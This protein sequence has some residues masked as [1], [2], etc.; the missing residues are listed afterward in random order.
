MIEKWLAEVAERFATIRRDV[1]HV[2]SA[3]RGER[4]PLTVRRKFSDPGM[5]TTKGSASLKLV[6][7]DG[8]LTAA[9]SLTP[10]TVTVVDVIHETSQAVTLVVE[11]SSER[12]FSEAFAHF[13]PGQFVTVVTKID[14]VEY[15]RAYSICTTK[16]QFPRWAITTKRVRDGKVS[17]YLNEKIQ[18]GATL[19]VLGPSGNFVV[20]PSRAPS[21]SVR[22]LL[23]IAGG[24]GITPVFSMI[25]SLLGTDDSLRV[26][27]VYGNLNN[28]SIIF[29]DKLDTLAL[30]HPERLSLRHV[31]E[32]GAS[33]MDAPSTRTGR[34]D[35]STL[36]SLWNELALPSHT[37]CFLCG[38]EGMMEAAREM[39]LAAGVDRTA[40][41]EEK[42]SSPQKSSGEQA[43]QTE[44]QA[45]FMVRGKPR[46]VTI[47]PGKYLLESGIEAG[48][49]L[50]FSCT[51][52][53][54]GACKSKLSK[55]KVSMVEPNCLLPS[56]EA[57]GDIL[58]CVSTCL[59]DVTV[60]VAS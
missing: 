25:Q 52:G 16:E 45:T 3:L 51:M 10:R 7:S 49:D 1:A 5:P 15:R 24:S 11:E 6:S 56:E 35:R 59:S 29:R 4:A 20:G 31:L 50:P 30:N 47:K 18:V 38:P 17:N 39:L 43:V 19:S 21:D 27:L 42:F 12:L 44:Y 41:R 46:L 53:G 9:R 37:E 36:E 40:I 58:P 26:T 34:L 23:F 2:S 28:E 55:G 32:E 60:E 8:V 13:A 14:G 57:E 22:Q 33:A 48:L 54:C